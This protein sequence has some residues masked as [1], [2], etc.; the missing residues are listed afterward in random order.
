[1]IPLSLQLVEQEVQPEGWLKTA[2]VL[3]VTYPHSLAEIQRYALIP[4]WTG[5]SLPPP[6]SEA[7]D[8]LFPQ[9]EPESTETPEPIPDKDQRLV[10]LW[11]RA[12]SKIWHF[13]IQDSQIA[14]WFEKN[15]HLTVRLR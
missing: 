8:D 5:S 1:M 12:K 7:P 14:N 6:D 9:E 4:P 3:N 2:H 10:D 15:C 11:A 13:D